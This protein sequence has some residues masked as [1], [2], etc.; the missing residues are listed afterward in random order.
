MPD[1]LPQMSKQEAL[2]VASISSLLNG[3]LDR[4]TWRI[5]PFR[6]P[7]HSSSMAALVGGGSIPKPGEISLAHN[8]VLF[9]DELPE[10]ERRVLDA[11][12]E[13]IEAG[14]IIISRASGKMCFPARFQLIAAL[15]PSPSGQ[16]ASGQ[17]RDNPQ[18]IL[19]Y[20]SRISGPFLDRFDMS[21]EIPLL[22]MGQLS[23]GG[24]RGETTEQISERVQV[25]RQ[26]MMT[27]SGKINAHLS[28]KEIDQYCALKKTD[29]QFLEEAIVTLGL[30][31][32]AYHRIIK[33]ARTIADLEGDEEV[34]RTHLLEALGYR[35]MDR[36]LIEISRSI[37]F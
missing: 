25:T 9:L 26:L 28:N 6:S 19:R 20:L 22:P 11:L 5:R 31:I 29:A 27:R 34:N 17:I 33:V 2:E 32:R 12:R 1:L 37:S 3:H 13:P 14:E 30:S 24:D 18:S 8:G 23:E 35:A 36:L 16:Y 7:H 4:D 15:N 21:V 10:F